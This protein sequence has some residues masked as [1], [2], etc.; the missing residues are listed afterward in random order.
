M[1]YESV[2][3]DCLNS[4]GLGADAYHAVP[5]ERPG[6]FVTVEQT[7][8]SVSSVVVHSPTFAIGCW[9]ATRREAFALA[10]SVSSAVRSMPGCLPNCFSS[11]VESVF[12]N[13]DP[14]GRAER[15]Q[16]VATATFNE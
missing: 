14:H 6:E 13:P 2:V 11:S 12:R 7:G 3:I 15:Y 4:A 1:D 8:E 9:A 16:V 10:E 5:R